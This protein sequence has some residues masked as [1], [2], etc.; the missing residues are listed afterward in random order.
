MADIY[1]H[2]SLGSC[3]DY[4]TETLQE[5]ERDC[6]DAVSGILSGMRAMGNMAFWACSSKN[7]PAEQAME[8]LRN[9]GE[10]MMYLPRIVEALNENAQSARYELRQRKEKVR[11]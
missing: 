10:S 9:M 5:I 11:K 7:Y 8:D 4:E 1:H 3:R 6:D 2:I